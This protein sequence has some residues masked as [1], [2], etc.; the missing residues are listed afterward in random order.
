M[1]YTT[2]TTSKGQ[3]TIPKEVRD[4]IGLKK[5]MRVEIYPTEDG[6]EGKLQRKSRI[7]DFAG[8]LKNL[9]HGETLKEIRLKT[10]ELASREIAQKRKNAINRN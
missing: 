4:K 8:D 10:Q 9:D 3:L 1:S 5:G 2:T 6:F 7:L